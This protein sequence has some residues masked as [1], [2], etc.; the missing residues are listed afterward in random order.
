L[1]WKKRQKLNTYQ[2]E[3]GEWEIE[4][5]ALTLYRIKK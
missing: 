3:I 2:I 1:K 4:T 5:P